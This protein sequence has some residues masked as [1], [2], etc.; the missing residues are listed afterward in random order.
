M[1]ATDERQ[2]KLC[3]AVA[4]AAAAGILS[5]NLIFIRN[6]HHI[7]APQIFR[8]FLLLTLFLFVAEA[9]LWAFNDAAQAAENSAFILF[10]YNVSLFTSIAIYR[11]FFHPLRNFPGPLGVRVSKFWHVAKLLGQPN[12]KVLEEW[13]QQYGDFVRTGEHHVLIRT[14]EKVLMRDMFRP[15]RNLNPLSLS[16]G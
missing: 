14:A 7:R 10:S 11:I 13:H 2:S 3:I 15:K 6:E 9:R 4:A 16:N 8:F 5:H 12:F 1:S